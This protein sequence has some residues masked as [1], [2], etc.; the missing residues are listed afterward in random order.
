MSISGESIKDILEALSW[1]I[2][3]FDLKDLNSFMISNKGSKFS[4]SLISNELIIIDNSN[5][6]P[7]YFELTLHIKFKLF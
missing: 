4:S 7:K 6:I 1:D 5:A 3:A 2:I